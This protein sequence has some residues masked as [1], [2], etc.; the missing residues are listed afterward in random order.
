MFLD[1]K[2]LMK[3]LLNIG[4]NLTIFRETGPWLLLHAIL[5]WRDSLPNFNKRVHHHNSRRYRWKA[6]AWSP[7]DILSLIWHLLRMLQRFPA[8]SDSV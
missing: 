3:I 2:T 8:T 4:L 5:T 1:K 7:L 6:G